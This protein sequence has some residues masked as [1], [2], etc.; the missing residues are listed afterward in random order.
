MAS[1][2]VRHE[3]LAAFTHT[4]RL[5]WFSSCTGIVSLVGVCVAVLR[6][7]PLAL[8]LSF[9]GAELTLSLSL[10]AWQL[11]RRQ[12]DWAAFSIV[13]A[14]SFVWVTLPIAASGS[15]QLRRR[16]LSAWWA[17]LVRRI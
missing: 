5:F 9:A 7:S 2:A 1:L 8:S 3:Q 6:A 4:K 11:V 13:A 14:S 15:M 12:G 16:L 10:A 17:L